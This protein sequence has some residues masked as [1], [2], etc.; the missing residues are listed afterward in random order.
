MADEYP[1]HRAHRG[2]GRKHLQDFIKANSLGATG[3]RPAGRIHPPKYPEK[4]NRKDASSFVKVNQ[5]APELLEALGKLDGGNYWVDDHDEAPSYRDKTGAD[6]RP[7]EDQPDEQPPAQPLVIAPA[8]AGLDPEQQKK[9]LQAKQ[10]AKTRAGLAEHIAKGLSEHGLREIP[11]WTQYGSLA[12]ALI[13]EEQDF[14]GAVKTAQQRGLGQHGRAAEY[15][16]D[17]ALG[18][19]EA[20]ADYLGSFQDRLERMEKTPNFFDVI[21]QGTREYQRWQEYKSSDLARVPWGHIALKSIV[22]KPRR[23]RPNIP[24]SV[25]M[26]GAPVGVVGSRKGKARSAIWA[27]ETGLGE[28][29]DIEPMGGMTGEAPHWKKAEASGLRKLRASFQRNR[30]KAPKIFSWRRRRRK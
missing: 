11:Y 30:R 21:P 19:P 29:P 16:R 22:P 13:G 1:T 26:G 6:T 14:A 25:G 23:G 7:P 9:A 28:D 3:K 20:G 12:K 2:M 18:E 24:I 8:V 5:K 4:R 15:L 27:E 17:V 10:L